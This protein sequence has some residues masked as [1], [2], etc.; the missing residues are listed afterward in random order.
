VFDGWRVAGGTGSEEEREPLK[1]VYTAENETADMYIERELGERLAKDKKKMPAVVSND[2]LIRLC[3]IRLGGLRLGCEDFA[4][5]FGKTMKRLEKA[6]RA[7]GK[8]I[9]M[10]VIAEEKGVKTHE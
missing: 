6:A 4:E 7:E 1:V 8:A 10:P 2:N 5:E 3:V 9:G